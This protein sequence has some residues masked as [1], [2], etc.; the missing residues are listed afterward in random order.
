MIKG[1]T[2][3]GFNFEIDEATLNNMEV[4]DALVEIE[5][6]GNTDNAGRVLAGTSKLMSLVLS[7]E[8][9]KA[10]Y[11]HVR[12]ENGQV[13]LAACT[14]ELMEIIRYNGSEEEDNEEVKNV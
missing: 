3:T 5:N 8:C 10:L 11:D 1:K 13:P 7:K 14:K 6:A 2:S 9:K 12:T 4:I